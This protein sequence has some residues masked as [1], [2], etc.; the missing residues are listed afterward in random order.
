[1]WM[2]RGRT[3]PDHVSRYWNALVRGAAPEELA[4]LSAP[5]EPNVVATI[6]RAHAL[7]R[8]QRPDPA[9]ANRLENEL[10]H[11]FAASH[12]GRVTSVGSVSIP[13]NGRT[14]APRGWAPAERDRPSR[15]VPAFAHLATAMLVAVTLFGAYLAFGNRDDRPAI[16]P[17]VSSPIPAIAITEAATPAPSADAVADA[18]LVSAT[19]AEEELPDGRVEAVFYR[20]TLDPG[21][22]LSYLAGPYCRCGNQV[23]APG[24]GVE[25]VESGSYT[26]RLD[27]PVRLTRAGTNVV[28]EVPAET[29]L[30]LNAGDAVAL[31]NYAATGEIRNSG[32]ESLVVIGVAI[33]AMDVPE[34]TPVPAQPEGVRTTQLT[35]T[36]SHEWEKMP[37]GGVSI[38][39]R[40]VILEPGEQL[41][42][43]DTIGFETV[44][45]E[46]GEM[47][48]GII[49]AG[50]S[51]PLGAPSGYSP[52]RSTAFMLLDPNGVT[53]EIENTGDE[54]ATL[55]VLS[56]RPIDA[57]NG[58][59][60][61]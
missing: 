35:S 52:G 17:N 9:F 58:T 7:H 20:L 56:I 6:D 39:L 51:E 25:V 22:S 10:M 34:G 49:P 4:R 13:L 12:A 21:A 27:A 37:P 5:L 15:R 60:S 1:M 8:R 11:A 47:A 44:H 26:I 36:M 43:V 3:A 29:E 48:M 57:G 38:E 19:F 31:P 42:P 61:P 24:V 59:P 2:R 28:E 33:I 53:R 18:T 32:T 40:R 55:L 46:A 50:E 45:L 14:P 30:T 23:I 16:A 41:P 54:P